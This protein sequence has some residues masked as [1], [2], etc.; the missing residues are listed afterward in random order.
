MPYLGDLPALVVASQDGYSVFVADF[1]SDEESDR[2]HRIVASIHVVTHKQVIR[3]R[4][5][6]AYN[7]K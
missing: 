5:L 2:L 1:Q 3:I 4:T 7:Q 6:T